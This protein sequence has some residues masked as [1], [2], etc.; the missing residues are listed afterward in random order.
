MRRKEE[1]KADVSLVFGCDETCGICTYSVDPIPKYGM[2][3]PAKPFP[4]NS[5]RQHEGRTLLMEGSNIA[6]NSYMDEID[7]VQMFDS[8]LSVISTRDDLVIHKMPSCLC[9]M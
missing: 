3:Y 2:G 9:T 8:G 5:L 1:M 7:G 4:C 6:D